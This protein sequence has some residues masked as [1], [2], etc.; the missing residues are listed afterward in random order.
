M[1]VVVGGEC[2]LAMAPARS[3]AWPTA[4]RPRPR[5][6]PRPHPLSWNAS[7]AELAEHHD[8]SHAHRMSVAGSLDEELLPQGALLPP[9]HGGGPGCTPGLAPPSSPAPAGAL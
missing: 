2:V 8:P 9:A 5:P 1:V 6:H 7:V 3:R 4:C